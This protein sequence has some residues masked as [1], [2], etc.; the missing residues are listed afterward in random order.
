MSANDVLFTPTEAAVLTRLPLKAVNNAIDKDMVPTAT[1]DSTRL[2][3]PRALLALVLEKRLEGRLFPELRRRLFAALLASPRNVISLE[4]GT[5]TVKVDLRQPRRELAA[6]LKALRRARVLIA[7]DREI[8]GGDPVFRGTRV[9]VHL[10]GTLL[11]QGG[12]EAQILEAYPRLTGEMIRLAT[13]Y[14]QAY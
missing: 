7:S 14:A 2:L 6:R 9:S 12:T 1:R 3:D 11:E 13:V 4:D 5:V 8:M 10:I